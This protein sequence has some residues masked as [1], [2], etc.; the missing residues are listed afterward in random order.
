MHFL[1]LFYQIKQIQVL[2]III[3][4]KNNR[5]FKNQQTLGVREG[6]ALGSDTQSRGRG[7]A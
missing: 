5:G 4:N 7:I 6:K 2:R 3:T 1:F